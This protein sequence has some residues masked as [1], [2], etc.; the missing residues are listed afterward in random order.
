MDFS[1]VLVI[2]HPSS[3]YQRILSSRYG[4]CLHLVFCFVSSDAIADMGTCHFS[5][6]AGPILFAF[7]ITG[8]IF[9][10]VLSHDLIYT[11]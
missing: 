5:R 8:Y 11:S 2:N 6:I 3:R 7:C 4:K 10:K 9:A 1:S